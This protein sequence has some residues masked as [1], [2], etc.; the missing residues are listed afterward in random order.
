L[1]PLGIGLLGVLATVSGC[2]PP[3]P[4]VSEHPIATATVGVAVSDQE[5]SESVAFRQR[6]GLRADLTW[7]RAVARNPAA[8]AGIPEFGL[9]LMPD[10][11]A[12][13]MS[14][15]WDPDLFGQVR[16]YGLLFPDDFAGAY[17]N[18]KGSGV[19]ISFKNR[20]ERHRVALSNLVPAGSI[21]E[22]REVD[23][24]LKDLEGFVE[25]VE[26]ED[27]WFHSAGISA[28]AGAYIL[29]NS[30]HIRFQGPKDAAGL[31]E[32]HFGNPSWLR[33][34]WVG[35][36]P[37]DGPRADLTIRVTDSNGEPVPRLWCKFNPV[38][39]DVEGPGEEVWGTDA[40]GTCFLRNLPAALYKIELHEWI[41]GVG[42][43][44]NPILSF[45]T[46][47]LPGGTKAIVVIPRT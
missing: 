38:S 15:R 29:D 21:V 7:V 17:I 47:L 3:A 11:L 23:W 43:S 44:P 5:I 12:D 33:A 4:A 10:E 36:P 20:V 37:W 25:W 24:S 31:I 32:Q 6:F 22:V 18:L 35:P 41:D 16:A 13:L 9:A 40:S 34:Q 39:P 45:T 30:V 46:E 42:Y 19:T 14:R 26:A 1:L 27:A 2:G 28:R 8:Q